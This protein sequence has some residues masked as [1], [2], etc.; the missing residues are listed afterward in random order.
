MS[1]L[2]LAETIFRR[3]CEASLYASLSAHARTCSSLNFVAC[4]YR[5][6]AFNFLADGAHKEK[7][8]RVTHDEFSIGH[9]GLNL[10]HASRDL[11]QAPMAQPRFRCVLSV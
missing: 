1:A 9:L 6:T 8:V 11:V 3:R 7:E 5:E 4:S 10:A 2:L